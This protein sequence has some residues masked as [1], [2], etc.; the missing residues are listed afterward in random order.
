M[1][2][3]FSIPTILFTDPPSKYEEQIS[4]N[5]SEEYQGR[6]VLEF[7]TSL[8]TKK[9]FDS[10]YSLLVTWPCI[11]CCRC[12]LSWIWP[13]CFSSSLFF[14]CSFFNFFTNCSFSSLSWKGREFW[15]SQATFSDQVFIK[16]ITFQI[17][18][19]SQTFYY[20]YVEVYKHMKESSRKNN[21]LQT[22]WRIS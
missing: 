21:W 6:G 1:P 20:I 19:L 9:T 8:D 2:P 15:K 11:N 13:S 18:I 10:S 17:K 16:L 3:A 22:L 12:S 7:C 5:S 14:M 4:P